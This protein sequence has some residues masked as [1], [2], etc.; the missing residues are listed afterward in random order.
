M[1]E[2]LQ[3]EILQQIFRKVFDDDELVLSPETARE[4]IDMWDSLTHVLMVG[5]VESRFNIKFQL[6]EIVEIRSVGDILS[7]LNKH[8]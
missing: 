5:E 8:S 1:N 3:L 6:Q 2:V 7:L 4:D